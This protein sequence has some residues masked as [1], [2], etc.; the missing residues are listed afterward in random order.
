MGLT[1]RIVDWMYVAYDGDHT[2][3]LVN[4]EMIIQV[5]LRARNILIRISPFRFSR[6]TLSHGGS[7]LV[8]SNCKSK[9]LCEA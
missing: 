5:P 2:W 3:A 8:A 4:A 9:C 1:K 7:S 6:M